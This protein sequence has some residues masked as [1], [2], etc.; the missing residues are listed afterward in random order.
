ME[1]IYTHDQDALPDHVVEKIFSG[2]NNKRICSFSDKEVFCLPAMWGYYVYGFKGLAVEIEVEKSLVKKVQYQKKAA[3]WSEGQTPENFLNQILITKLK[4]WSH[5]NEYRYICNAH[6]DDYQKIGRIKAVHF[7]WPYKRVGNV[8]QIL[9]NSQS[10][11]EYIHRVKQ[12]LTIATEK[13]YDIYATHIDG[14]KVV[15]R[16]FSMAEVEALGS[17]GR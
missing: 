4:C 9:D 13:D 11:R 6:Q 3:H 12:L 2:K 17:R 15:S 8:N 16:P 1:G 14:A 7:G 10:L 5:E